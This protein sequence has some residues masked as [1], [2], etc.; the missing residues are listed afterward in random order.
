MIFPVTSLT[1]WLSCLS[2]STY[3]LSLSI[4]TFEDELLKTD[5]QDDKSENY[6]FFD[7]KRSRDAY[8]LRR[9]VWRISYDINSLTHRLIKTSGITLD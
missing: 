1:H 9:E 2:E 6:Y 5:E 8:L 3:E 4:G 7:Q